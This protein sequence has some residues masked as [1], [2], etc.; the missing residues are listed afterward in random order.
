MVAALADA[1][2]GQPEALAAEWPGPPRFHIAGSPTYNVSNEEKRDNSD[3]A[4]LHSMRCVQQI[5]KTLS[6]AGLF[7]YFFHPAVVPIA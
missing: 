3:T 5:K 1:R 2:D 4:A 7:F 6:T